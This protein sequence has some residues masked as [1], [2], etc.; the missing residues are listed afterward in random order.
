[1]ELSQI[2]G[3]VKDFQT[4]FGGGFEKIPTNL[5]Q[6]KTSLRFE[7]MAEENFEYLD[8]CENDDLIG[9]ADALGDMLYILCGTILV[10]G[11]QDIIEPVFQ[12]I[13]RSN[14]SKLDHRGLP[15][16]NGQNGVLDD[17]RPLGKVLKSE[18]YH[19]PVLRYIVSSGIINAKREISNQV[20]EEIEKLA[21]LKSRC[22]NPEIAAKYSKEIEKCN[23]EILKYSV[24]MKDLL[25]DH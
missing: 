6:D 5:E 11:M 20:F 15:I 7:L 4:A 14:M 24:T 9:I 2:I 18:Q 22:D 23:Q 10:H 1:M 19:P 8:A 25:N 3:S 13:H 16:I 17:T 21:T 12:E